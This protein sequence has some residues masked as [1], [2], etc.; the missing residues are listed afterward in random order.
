MPKLSVC[1]PVE[2][3]FAAPCSL[4]EALLKQREMDVEVIVSLFESSREQAQ[5]LYE[6]AEND[7]RLKILPPA[8]DNIT[9]AQLWIGTLQSACGDW[10]TLVYPDDMLEPDLPHLLSHIEKNHPQADALGWNSI[11]IN[12]SAT[13]DAKAAVAIPVM[14]QVSEFDK[15]TM[16][17]AFFNWTNAPQ[18]PK[19]PF[20][21]F[22]GALKRSL[23]DAILGA[24]AP[25]SWL[26]PVPRFEWTAR[27]VLFANELL[28]SSRPMSATSATPYQPVM[29]RSALEGF[30]FDGSLGVTAAIAEV[31]AR[32]LSELGSEWAG[33][34]E[35][36][37]RSCSVDCILEHD[38][39]AYEK[40]C[41][42]YQTAIR[43][44]PGG[45]H[46]LPYFQPKFFP[47][48]PEDKR[49]GLVG[50]TLL[51]DRFIGNAQTAQEFYKVVRS[52]LA[53]VFVV[54][55]RK[56]MS[57]AELASTG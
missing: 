27:V 56:S 46:L 24:S 21:L 43:S 54:T 22:H 9:A 17:D 57:D 33:F 3:D 7:G 49:R 8:P 44:M 55:G 51:V 45:E 5:P 40:R 11:Q 50:Q 53:P 37:V 1:I 19:V 4:V 29:V 35:H 38:P 25:T 13:R 23:V 30:P 18:V 20:G 6:R 42:A 31:Q 10:V 47:E 2:P 39:M 36:F 34:N 15:A 12:P 14:H 16:L 26:T 28:L 41:L 48:A 52:M 32:V